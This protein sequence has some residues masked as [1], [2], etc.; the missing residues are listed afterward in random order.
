MAST[1]AVL[2]YS[3]VARYYLPGPSVIFFFRE[4]RKR[5]KDSSKGDIFFKRYVR[6]S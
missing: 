5:C 3:L 4:Q 2:S 1:R 6:F